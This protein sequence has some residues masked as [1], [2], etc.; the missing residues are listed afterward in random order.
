MK[1]VF[2]FISFCLLLISSIKAFSEPLVRGLK[3]PKS[4]EELV[5]E[6]IT[7]RLPDMHDYS[8]FYWE[9]PDT[10]WVKKVRKPVLNK[11]FRLEKKGYHCDESSDRQS[12]PA[13]FLQEKKFIVL[14][15]EQKEDSD[16][17]S[18]NG[19]YTKTTTIT[20][21]LKSVN[22]GELL[23]WELFHTAR[24]YADNGG[25]NAGIEIIVDRLSEEAYRRLPYID[26]YHSTEKYASADDYKPLHIDK[27]EY[28][29]STTFYYE[30]E[31]RGKLYIY[32]TKDNSIEIKFE[33][34]DP[35]VISIEVFNQR[36]EEKQRRLAN[37]GHFIAQLTHVQKPANSK[38]QRGKITKQEVEDKFIYT[39]NYISI[40]MGAMEKNLV[41]VL[42]NKTDYSM[43]VL[44]DEASFIKPGGSAQRVLHNGVRFVE[45]SQ[46]QAPSVIPGH[47]TLNEA[48]VPSDNIRY[49]SIAGEWIVDP[50][51]EGMKRKDSFAS[52]STFSVLLPIQISG[53][54]NEYT[55]TFT[56]T[57]VYNNPEVREEYLKTHPE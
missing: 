11:H 39:D 40:V 13:S 23:Y 4:F 47:A 18:W 55:F 30:P 29:I 25:Y 48:I 15:V 53:V 54:T 34:R 45:K 21:H 35:N 8:N 19:H 6:T 46:P 31:V 37:E 5:N 42:Q 20:I 1:K 44:W 32:G 52:G 50:L 51:L 10:V 12:T 49:S 14:S 17:Q 26:C 56:L 28:S 27:T 57:W 43:K 38:I 36:V 41:F 22:S 16:L 24:N 7:L 33:D 2:V 3:E 9:T